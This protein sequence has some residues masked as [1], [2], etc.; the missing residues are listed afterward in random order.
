METEIER[1]AIQKEK[2]ISSFNNLAPIF[3]GCSSIVGLSHWTPANKVTAH[4]LLQLAKAPIGPAMKLLGLE[5]KFVCDKD[6]NVIDVSLLAID[7]LIA[8]GTFDGLAIPTEEID[9]IIYYGVTREYAEPATATI[10]QNRLGLSGAISYDISNACLGFSDAWGIADAMIESGRIRYALLV[11]A[12]ILSTVANAS[13]ERINQGEDYRE[14]IAA[15]TLG[16]AASAALIGKQGK[17]KKEVQLKAGVRR[18]YSQH[19]ELCKMKDTNSPMYTNPSPMFDAAQKELP[20]LAESILNHLMWDNKDLDLVFSHQA[21]LPSLKTGCKGLN[22][23]FEMAP[24]TFSTMGNTASV[25][26]PLTLSKELSERDGWSKKR[27]LLTG[28]G[29]GLGIAVSGLTIHNN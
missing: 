23:P 25:A 6:A 18:T 15:L 1:A 11:S 22:I 10:L 12:E 29:S 20:K 2:K 17:H 8:Q 16:D 7:L 24:N 19:S 21:S 5:S 14:H 28:F 27:T 9:L 4:S 26:V 3:D 13:L